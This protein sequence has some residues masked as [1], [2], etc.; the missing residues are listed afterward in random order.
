MITPL[1]DMKLRA[2]DID[3]TL[4]TSSSPVGGSFGPVRSFGQKN[5]QGWDLLA[6]V[7][8]PIFA[9]G[10]GMIEGVKNWGD[11]G[12]QIL[13]RF[14]RPIYSAPLYA[15]YAHLS[16]AGVGKM[17]MVSEGEMLGLTGISGNAGGTSP[18]LHFEIRTIPWPGLGLVGRID[19][20]DIL[21]YQYY[22]CTVK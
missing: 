14:N 21:G 3:N 8:T 5:H 11:Y 17:K 2:A 19:P 4:N 18:H 13:L 22:S 20:G 1:V 9:I 12:L 6:P 7:G 16:L 15:F 10:S